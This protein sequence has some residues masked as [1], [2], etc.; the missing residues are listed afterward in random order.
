MA[1]DGYIT[2][3]I[4]DCFYAGTIPL[5]L[6][7]PDIDKY[8]PKD[9]YIDCRD[10]KSWTEMLEKITSMPA[11]EIEAKREAGRSYLRSPEGRRFFNSFDSI[12]QLSE[13]AVTVSP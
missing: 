5:Y 7:A 9:C 13:P 12:L 8:I 10:F 4:I 6:G 2:E 3:K 11:S 1:M